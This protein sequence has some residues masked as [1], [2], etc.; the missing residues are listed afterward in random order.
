[1]LLATGC[2]TSEPGSTLRSDSQEANPIERVDLNLEPPIPA[3]LYDFV[4]SKAQALAL[5]EYS[6][7]DTSLPA[8]LTDIDYSEYQAIRFDHESAIWNGES[9]FEVHLFHRGFLF[10]ERVRIHM[11]DA[12]VAEIPF[13]SDLFEYSNETVKAAAEVATD[14]GYSGFRV[15]YPLNNPDVLDEVIVFQGASYFRLLGPGH[16]YGLSGRGLAVRM[17]GPGAEEFPDFKEFWLVKPEP[18]DNTFAFYGLL[19]S[20]S[21]TGAYQF[22][23]VPEEN[24]TVLKVDAQLF[25]R[26]DVSKLGVAPMSSMFLYG[27]NRAR[28]YDDFRLEVHDSDGLLM[29]TRQEEWIWRPLSNRRLART[30]SLRDIE[31]RGFGLVQRARDFDSYLDLEALYHRRPSH[32]VHPVEGDWGGGGVELLEL[33]TNSEFRDNIAIAWVPDAPFQAGQERHYSYRLTTFDKRLD[34]QTLAQVERTGIGRDALPGEASPVPRSQRRFIVDF[35]GGLLDSLA[36]YEEIHPVLDTSSGTISDLQV[37]LLPSD[38]GWRVSFR[39]V[40]DAEQPADMRLYLT[41]LERPVSETWTYVWYP[42]E[43]Q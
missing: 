6:A 37:A 20:P 35:A 40:P 10:K 5:I 41:S 36:S 39:L 26:D 3:N 16:V 8:D 42:D 27:P 11:V 28:E 23:L 43:L 18:G 30:T 32:W 7:P 19:D 31:P 12:E 33:P 14:L 15:T 2:G 29:Q 1:M 24:T 22:E 13:N 21:L 34:E 4:L 9:P 17:G 38:L 25:A